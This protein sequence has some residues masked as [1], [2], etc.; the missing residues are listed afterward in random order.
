MMLFK[1]KGRKGSKASAEPSRQKQGAIGRKKIAFGRDAKNKANQQA[2]H[3]IDQKGAKK[4]ILK[5]GIKGS[6]DE[7]TKNASQSTSQKNKKSL[8]HTPKGIN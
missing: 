7:I 4:K 2:A 5:K 3:H 1:S 8:L 6:G